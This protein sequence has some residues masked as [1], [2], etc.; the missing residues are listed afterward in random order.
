MSTIKRKV[1]KANRYMDRLIR[2]LFFVLCMGIIGVG[3]LS[4]QPAKATQRPIV[5]EIAPIPQH[6]PKPTLVFATDMETLARA[7][8]T[9]NAL[10]P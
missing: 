2:R 6:K 4:W 5:R 10:K 9:T 3:V 8:S 7:I 1:V